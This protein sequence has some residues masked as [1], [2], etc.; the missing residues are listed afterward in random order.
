MGRCALSPQLLVPLALA[1]LPRCGM[2][3]GASSEAPP[4]TPE[5]CAQ[6]DCHDARESTVLLEQKIDGAKGD[7]EAYFKLQAVRNQRRKEGKVDG[8]RVKTGMHSPRTASFLVKG[9]GSCL[10]NLCDAS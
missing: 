2:G 5:G 10:T 8:M 1:E 3:C 4:A 9:S 6:I 7:P